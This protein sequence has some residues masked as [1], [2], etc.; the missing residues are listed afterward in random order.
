MVGSIGEEAGTGDRGALGAGYTVDDGTTVR[1]VDFYA[2]LGVSRGAGRPQVRRAWR[3][4]AATCH[5]DRMVGE[6]ADVAAWGRR[7]W[8][9]LDTAVSVLCSA[10]REHYDGMLSRW[11]GKWSDDAGVG[12]RAASEVVIDLRTG[13]YLSDPAD[14][15][16]HGVDL[17]L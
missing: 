7:Y 11:A 4:L 2:F 8:D 12:P 17:V 10:E 9:L 6:P 14:P 13:R 15:R 1:M 3:R 16:P 5:P